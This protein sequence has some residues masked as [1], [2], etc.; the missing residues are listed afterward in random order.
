VTEVVLLARSYLAAAC[1]VLPA[2]LTSCQS[3]RDSS[4]HARPKPVPTSSQP[5]PARNTGSEP[6]HKRPGHAASPAQHPALIHGSSHD[7]PSFRVI[8]PHR[9]SE[10][11]LQGSA[12]THCAPDHSDIEASAQQL[13]LRSLGPDHRHHFVWMTAHDFVA[14]DP[15]VEHIQHMFGVELYTKPLDGLRSPHV[16]GLLQDGSLADP[17]KR[18]FG[19][20]RYGLKEAAQAISRAGGLAVLAHPS[21]YSPTEASLAEVGT[22]L[23][24]IE[25]LSGSTRPEENLTF[26]DARLSTGVY[27]CLSAGGDIHKEDYKLTA[28]YQIVA[29]PRPTL[30]RDELFEAVRN[31]NFFACGVKSPRHGPIRRPQLQVR[32]DGIHFSSK[33]ALDSIRFIGQHGKVLH[34]ARST[35]SARYEPREEDFYVRI[36]A[37]SADRN[38]RCYSQPLWIGPPLR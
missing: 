31:C 19:V 21:R 8:S 1:I 15:G 3:S 36:E 7:F 23:W 26:I 32:N 20:Y 22:E 10:H 5:Q 28:G 9:H 4:S 2:G 34:E 14:P 18:P 35:I 17:E 13:R 30:G 37:V 24:G 38:A 11:E 33:T 25:V 29:S 16:I 12:H 6:D 27:T